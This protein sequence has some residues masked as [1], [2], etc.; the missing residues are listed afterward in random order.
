MEKVQSPFSVF[1]DEWLNAQKNVINN[2]T[3]FQQSYTNG[4]GHGSTNGHTANPWKD[5]FGMQQGW[6]ENFQKFF[7]G[8]SQTEMGGNAQLKDWLEAQTSF[9]NNYLNS[10]KSFVETLGD[11]EKTAEF[12]KQF[13]EFQMKMLQNMLEQAKFFTN[14]SNHPT[15]NFMVDVFGLYERWKDLYTNALGALSNT[16]NTVFTGPSSDIM[17]DTLSRVM[18]SS[19][20]YLKLFEFLMP[21]F[22]AIQH[23]NFNIEQYQDL[24]DPSR[25][26]KLLDKVFEFA[27]PE[28]VQEFFN[29]FSNV[30]NAINTTSQK[31]YSAF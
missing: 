9:M 14:Q 15:G 28:T 5:W 6:V 1:F 2:F 27:T 30:N 8:A 18:G 7:P 23:K 25:Y 19:N 31:K 10:T 21:I 20:T 3:N 26:K 13:S 29:H 12:Y 16:A 22:N 11:S 17:R 24:L 4:N